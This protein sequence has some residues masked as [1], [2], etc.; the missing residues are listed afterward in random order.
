MSPNF[1][2][3]QMAFVGTVNGLERVSGG[4]FTWALMNPWN[5]KPT[6]PRSLGISPAFA[7]DSTIFIGTHDGI[8]YPK[9]VIYNGK[10]ILNQGLFISVDA[11]QSWAP[12]GIAGPPVDSIAV[13]P[14]FSADK[15]VFAGSATAGL[16]KSTTA[17]TTFKSIPLV[18]T[19]PTVLPVVLSPAYATDQTVFAATSHSGVY[20]SINGGGSWSQLPGTGLLTAFSIALSAN[21]ASD[22]TLFLGTLQQGLL[23]SIDGG[24][25]LVPLAVPGNFASAVAI[26]PGYT[27][28]HTIFAASY[29]GLYKSIDGGSTWVYTAEPGRQ[30]EQRAF[31][32]TTFFTILY[33]GSWP[34]S[35]VQ[36]ASTEQLATTTQSGATASLTF[37]GSGAQ[38][39]G[40][41]GP[42]SGS[43]Q[44]ILDGVLDATVNLNAPQSQAQQTLWVKRGL[45]CAVHTVTINA[46]PGSGQSVTLDALDV[47]QDTCA[48]ALAMP[49]A[50]LAL[51]PG[52]AK[53]EA[54]K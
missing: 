3:D 11:G 15:T 13:S 34:I 16:F 46:T 21:Y 27:Q 39:I 12:T 26:S 50:Q 18:P 7:Q 53:P 29:L 9:Y 38:W 43:A 4:N 19:D 5:H 47:W 28:D 36:S 23:K 8:N 54:V 30:E 14:N 20:K 22:Q 41:K 51:G 6:Y 1:A 25:T 48:W 33:Q 37:L 10:Q 45:P 42:T 32:P 24:N 44:V 40:M 52:E 49:A 31:P 35:Q 2:V 17:G